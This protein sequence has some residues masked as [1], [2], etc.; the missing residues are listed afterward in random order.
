MADPRRPTSWPAVL[1]HTPEPAP[2]DLA[3]LEREVLDRW[4]RTAVPSRSMTGK[5]RVP[6]WSFHQVPRVADGMPGIHQLP[7]IAIADMYRRL[8]AMQGFKVPRHRAP[9][10]HGLTLEVAVRDELALHGG[11]EIETYGPERFV[12]R[13]R[14]SALRHSAAMA[15]VTVRAGCWT[16]PDA[17]SAASDVRSIESVWAS[18]K[19]IFDAGLLVRDHRVGPYC[20]GCRTPL[21]VHDLR[22]P[23]AGNQESG[24]AVIV[25]L[26]LATLPDGANPRLRGADLLVEVTAPWTL[27]ANAALAVHPHL[28]YALARGADHDRQVIVAESRL[29][30]ILGDGWRVAARLSGAELAGARFLPAIDGGQPAGSRPVITSYGV[31][32]GSGTGIVHL[33]PAYSAQDRAACVAGGLDWPD[34]LG[35]DGRFADATPL[36]AGEFFADA[37]PLLI[38]FLTDRGALFA[39]R[40]AEQRHP[41]PSCQRCGT[42][43]LFRATSGWHLDTTAAGDPREMSDQTRTQPDRMIS[44]TGYLAAPLPIWECPR[45]HMTC[46]GSLSELSALAGLDTAGLDPHRP[47]IDAVTIACPRCGATGTRVP[48]V[49]DDWHDAWSLML[50]AQGRR[51]AQE[52][53]NSDPAQPGQQ[54]THVLLDTADE[55]GEWLSRMMPTAATP[56]SGHPRFAT[57]LTLGPMLDHRGRPMSRGFGNLVPP[58]PLIERYGAD[59]VRWYFAAAAP[60]SAAWTMSEHALEGI[61]ATVLLGYWN[62]AD[63]LVRS[64]ADGARLGDLWRPGGPGLAAPRARTLLDHWMLSELQFLVRDV[65]DD[66]EDF[67]SAAATARIAEFAGHLSGRY[68]AVCRDRLERNGDAEVRLAV[69]ASLHECLEVLTRLMAPITPFLTDHVWSLIRSSLPGESDS[70]HLAA[71]PL[72]EPRLMDDQVGRLVALA[73]RLRELGRGA[74]ATAGIAASQPLPR[75]IVA[76]DGLT[77]MRADLGAHLAHELDVGSVEVIQS[78]AGQARPGDGWVVVCEGTDLVALDTG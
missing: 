73:D 78:G 13:C 10:C 67:D 34:P 37:E 8:K 48:E 47:Y 15:A 54:H 46:V 61:R 41:H 20:P 59:A 31:D 27:A 43:V 50:A 24:T 19:R 38:G 66:M 33:A 39:A 77:E 64:G 69:L 29:P 14:E 42:R 52:A 28:T 22:G 63:F 1:A 30:D 5:T 36:V 12:A 58:L 70:V 56:A 26:R 55:G 75:A 16:D 71:W 62:A 45:G 49:I 23:A 17:A 25:R 65:T 51:G 35:D 11:A 68:L 72:P 6:S 21:A 57:V 4:E 7:G 9:S 32:A 18:I 74:R 53:A 44:R 40:R 76:A 3:A 2:G 60:S